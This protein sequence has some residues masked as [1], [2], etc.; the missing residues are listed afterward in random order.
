MGLYECL[1][2]SNG[3]I[4]IYQKNFFGCRHV[5]EIIRII[6]L[7]ILPNFLQVEVHCFGFIGHRSVDKGKR[8]TD[9]VEESVEHC[10]WVV[11]GG[12]FLRYQVR[13]PQG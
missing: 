13:K 11:V 2:V 4:R 12:G 3:F 9:I 7:Y 5:D 1:D 10:V 6:I 8:H